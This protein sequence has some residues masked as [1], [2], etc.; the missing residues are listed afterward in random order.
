METSAQLILML[1]HNFHLEKLLET[2]SDHETS[3]QPQKKT[4]IS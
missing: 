3:E 4:G 1:T 2:S